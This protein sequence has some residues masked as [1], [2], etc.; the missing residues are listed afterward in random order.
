MTLPIFRFIWR[1]GY[2]HIA[3]EPFF[4]YLCNIFALQSSTFAAKMKRNEKL[5]FNL[6]FVDCYE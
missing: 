2:N 6:L 1:C 4:R 5:L 3:T